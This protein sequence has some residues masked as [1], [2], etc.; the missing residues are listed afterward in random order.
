MNKIAHPVLILALAFSVCGCDR[1]GEAED[2]VRSKPPAAEYAPPENYGLR[3]S[4]WTLTREAEA[5]LSEWAKTP[6][7]RKSGR[8]D[9]F[10]RAQLKYPVDRSDYLHHWYDRPL[11][12]DSSLKDPG[13]GT[14][15]RRWLNRKSF[16][17]TV[18][19]GRLG[20]QTGFAVFTST[21]GRGEALEA[22]TQAGCE[23]RILVELLKTLSL[24]ECL[25]RAEQALSCTNAFRI[26]GRVV[27]TSYP[28]ISEKDL[29]FYAR[30]KE[31][32]TERNG[33]RFL[34][35]PYYTLGLEEGDPL[36]GYDAARLRKMRERLERALRTLDGICY[37]GRESCFNRRYDPWLFDTVFVPLMHAVFSAPE[38]R[39][40]CLGCWA[41][42]GHENSYRWN[43]GLDSTGTRMLRDMLASVVKLGPDFMIGCE[44]DEE[45]E[46]TCFRPMVSHGFT[47]QRLMR[48]FHDT[49]NGE[50]LDVMP[51]DDVSVPN[52]VVSY[53]KE[54]M[55]G[56]P[57]EVEVLNIPD[58]SFDDE[59][60]IVS[61]SW[62]NLD[63]RLV[64]TF[65]ARKLSGGKLAAAWFNED[66]SALIAEPVLIPRLTVWARGKR[67]EF[68]DGFWPVGLRPTRCIEYKWAKHPLR[69]LP[70]GVSGGLTVGDAD[71]SGMRE[72]R[73]AVKSP[74]RLR[75]VAV[76]DETDTVYMYDGKSERDAD[77]VRVLIS[78][79]GYSFT[80]GKPLLNGRIRVDGA[81]NAKLS[82]A[83]ARGK[84]S[85]DGKS[86][87]FKGASVSHWPEYMTVVIPRPE[88][89]GAVIKVDI[90]G[91]FK[92]AV[93]VAELER[94][95]VTGI[96][97]KMGANLVFT[98]YLSQFD[99]PAPAMVDKAE[100]RFPLKPGLPNSVLRLEAVDEDYRV[101][102]SKPFYCGKPAGRK[103]S[104]NVYER[105]SGRVSAVEADASRF[106]KTR[107]EFKPSRGSVVYT[108]G[109]RNLWGILGGNVPLVTGFGR[110]ESSYGNSAILALKPSSSG[111]EKSSPDFTR[112]P[113]GSWSLE[114]SGCSYVSLPQQIWPV[115][116]SFT[117]EM[118]VKPEEVGRR[119]TLVFTGATSASLYL[120][121]GC[122]H[123]HFFL[124]NRFVSESGRAASVNVKGPPVAAGRWQKIRLVCDQKTAFIEVDGRRGE[125]VP[126]SGDLFYPLYTA[127][128]GGMSD[129]AFF[130]GK[131]RN[132]EVRD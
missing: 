79:Q 13:D 125:K 31:K 7:A 107:Y 121:D 75:S 33:D 37:N 99:I 68:S 30:L 5:L 83:R 94:D 36:N 38:F 50:P 27:L 44:W 132:F 63:G 87:V 123:A 9:F 72:I 131:I 126:V 86:F 6:Y 32:L 84:I 113:D 49:A 90:D 40:K 82:L 93:S 3:C 130:R 55:A 29:P 23:T 108:E 95:E 20:K 103:I 112:E 109:G 48:Y 17:R 76:I 98:R 56:E 42:P 73:G 69:E 54:L 26:N 89:A 12:Q 124:R 66:V 16:S 100:F 64:K 61:F 24:D 35:M 96:P 15:K 74:R 129:K 115:Q 128:G 101:W 110:G 88:A 60:I 11:L 57:L 106:L 28:G 118:E 114:F 46:N 85:V 22:C 4:G 2:S 39:D 102:R 52:L 41:T 8:T 81:A 119:Q 62:E 105:D 91:F 104:F 122:V 58:G 1:S 59:D 51:G 77:F 67:M 19:M 47:H 18:E 78:L 14:A 10:V 111:W 97:G 53:R 127:I 25:F 34:V 43:Y 120:A 21:S 65:P 45:N 117:L 92:G 71:A 80:G 70:G 116:S